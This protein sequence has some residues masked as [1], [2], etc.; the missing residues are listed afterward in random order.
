MGRSLWFLLAGI[1]SGLASAVYLYFNYQPAFIQLPI[2][3]AMF[4]A[5][6]LLL[7]LALRTGR[8]AGHRKL[9]GAYLIGAL[10]PHLAIHALLIGD[11]S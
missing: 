11:I 6:Y 8:S 10:P 4:V 7:S 1:A 9:L 3:G 5:A 2:H